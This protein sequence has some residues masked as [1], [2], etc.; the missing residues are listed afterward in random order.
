MAAPAP[1]RGLA[2]RLTRTDAC[3]VPVAALSPNRAITTA[4]FVELKMTADLYT[5]ADIQVPNAGGTVCV[6]DKGFS[7]LKGYN[8]EL[9]LCSFNES[10]L[11]MLGIGTILSDY[12]TPVE[13]VG[14][15]MNPTGSVNGAHV[16]L[17]IWAKN[18]NNNA[19]NTSTNPKRP[20]VQVVLPLTSHW[21]QTGDLTFGNA[22]A[23]MTFTGYA[24]SAAGYAKAVAAEEWTAADVTAIKAG[25]PVAVREVA[26]LPAILISQ[27]YDA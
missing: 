6:F 13:Q 24:Q 21:A 14:F 9:K 8:L 20:Y 7:S 10:V 22:E 2:M 18:A 4:A 12:T 16:Q 19:C 27:G 23:T 15:V 25:G 26:A 3:G 1:V 5:S 17:E 11:E